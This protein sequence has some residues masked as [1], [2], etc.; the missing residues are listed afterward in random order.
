M[1]T[2]KELCSS[3]PK[4]LLR[5]QTDYNVNQRKQAAYNKRMER[6]GMERA[7]FEQC[8]H[9]RT[10]KRV[11]NTFSSEQAGTCGSYTRTMR[12]ENSYITKV[13]KSRSMY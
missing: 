5:V 13:C 12:F 4:S 8:K 6:L 10:Q 3:V 11:K 1:A 7:I 9:T 2:L